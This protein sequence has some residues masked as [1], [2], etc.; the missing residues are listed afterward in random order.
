MSGSDLELRE[1]R[2]FLAV[3]EEGSFTEGARRCGVSQS[4]LSQTIR[5]LEDRF[6][7][8]LFDRGE[9]RVTATAAGKAFAARARAVAVAAEEARG[10]LASFADGTRGRV[11]VAVV[12]TVNAVLVP[13][14]LG[15]LTIASPSAT[16]G[17]LELSAPEVEEAV[18]SGEADFG[19]GFHP[20]SKPMLDLQPLGKEELVLVRSLERPALPDPVPAA[21]LAELPWIL[22]GKD[23]CTRRLVDAA[24]ALK[25]I[26]LRPKVETNSIEGILS[27]VRE[28]EL[29]S[30]LPELSL[31]TVAGSGLVGSSVQGVDLRRRLLVLWRRNGYRSPLAVAFAK[32][33]KAAAASVGKAQSPNGSAKPVAPG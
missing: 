25:G 18:A 20:V 29:V 9:R 28:G 4:A 12:Q 30:L 6:G 13:R 33:L 1:L 3:M 32:A 7:V 5:R 24:L 17:V 31:Q 19:V 15:E 14:L 2:H 21:M 27:V 10:A 11:T 16:F 23:Y 22:L 8:A 26:E